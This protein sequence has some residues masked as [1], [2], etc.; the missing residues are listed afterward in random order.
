[1]YAGLPVIIQISRLQLGYWGGETS[2]DLTTKLTNG[3]VKDERLGFTGGFRLPGR[4]SIKLKVLRNKYQQDPSQYPVASMWTT[5]MTEA[6]IAEF[7]FTLT[8]EA[9]KGTALR[10]RSAPYA[11]LNANLLNGVNATLE[12]LANGEAILRLNQNLPSWNG[13]IN[14][15]QNYFVRVDVLTP[16]MRKNTDAMWRFE[17]LD[18]NILPVNTNDELTTGFPLV[19][20][21]GFTLYAGRSPPMA[22][23]EVMMT[24]DPRGTMPTEFLMV[25]PDNYNFTE[26]CL[27]QGG[28]NGEIIACY[29]IEDV[30]GRQAAALVV[31]PPGL[32]KPLEDVIIAIVCPRAPQEEMAWYLQARDSQLDVELGWAEFSQGIEVKPMPFS[33]VIYAGD[34]TRLVTLVVT[35]QSTIRVP[36]GGKLRIGYPLG[37]KVNCEEEQNLA[38]N[39]EVGFFHKISLGDQATCVSKEFYSEVDITVPPQLRARSFFEITMPQALSPG[40][41][42]FAVQADVPDTITD[43]HLFSIMAYSPPSMRAKVIDAVMTIPGLKLFKALDIEPLP[44]HFGGTEALTTAPVSMGFKL[45]QTMP[46]NNGDLVF[47]EILIRIPPDFVHEVSSTQ[48]TLKSFTPMEL[49][50]LTPLNPL[51]SY[52]ISSSYFKIKLD[53]QAQKPQLRAGEYRFEFN[54]Q[55]PPLIPA[56]NVWILTLCGAGIGQYENTTCDDEHSPRALVSFPW[57]GFNMGDAPL[58]LGSIDGAMRPFHSASL[59]LVLALIM[60]T[61]SWKRSILS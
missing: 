38:E 60:C 28:A 3:E 26:N 19:A 31:K 50:Y 56:K 1:L 48:Q 55:I 51:L 22:E 57:P 39:A 58:G 25:A 54:V 20:G 34:P 33:G 7:T 44:F 46:P 42:A 59:W 18:S 37:W 21:I 49:P 47:S 11:I 17:I 14:G 36:P 52:N 24:I 5:R 29:R 16:A 45:N 4:V 23:I 35:F 15:Y 61:W 8:Q 13:T 32:L 41:Q 12:S 6:A 10:V 2:F 9:M 43:E 53:E 30:A 27:V 40:S